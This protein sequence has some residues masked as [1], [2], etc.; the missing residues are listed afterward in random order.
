MKIREQRRCNKISFITRLMVARARVIEMKNNVWWSMKLF[1]SIF[2]MSL[3]DASVFSA[4]NKLPFSKSNSVF[5]P[6]ISSKQIGHH[7]IL[8]EKSMLPRQRILADRIW[9]DTMTFRS[10]V[11]ESTPS[12]PQVVARIFFRRLIDDDFANTRRYKCWHFGGFPYEQRIR[13]GLYGISLGFQ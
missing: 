3:H 7:A 11:I 10:Y 4:N 2:T 13:I 8:R 6:S 9:E 12:H 5:I 1:T